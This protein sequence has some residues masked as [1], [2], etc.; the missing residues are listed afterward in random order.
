GY[1]TGWRQW[2]LGRYDA[3]V[4]SA[5]NVV[6][7]GGAVSAIFTSPPQ[8]VA[9]DPQSMTRYTMNAD[10][11]KNDA[12]SKVKWGSFHES[13]VD[14]MN[15]DSVDLADFHGHGGKLLIYHGVSDP[16]FS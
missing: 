16:V 4:N 6:L 12:A 7:A 9:A 1:F 10:V 15:A 11:E 3:D 8:P 5:A 14:F 13:S 2:K